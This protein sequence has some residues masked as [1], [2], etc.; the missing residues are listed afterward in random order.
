[1]SFTWTDLEV[2]KALGMNPDRGDDRVTYT[3]VSTDSREVAG[4]SDA[5]PVSHG[6]V[7]RMEDLL[8]PH[9]GVTPSRSERI[10]CPRLTLMEIAT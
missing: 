1:M 10:E 9:R 2:R 7:P 8:V 6:A 3:D 5:K 4:S